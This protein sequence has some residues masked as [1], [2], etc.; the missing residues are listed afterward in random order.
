MLLSFLL[1]FRFLTFD[2]RL[3]IW[4]LDF[5][6]DLSGML[7]MFGICCLGFVSWHCYTPNLSCRLTPPLFQPTICTSASH[8]GTHD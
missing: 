4:R 8:G 3:L 6:P 1:P 5:C 2:P 7:D